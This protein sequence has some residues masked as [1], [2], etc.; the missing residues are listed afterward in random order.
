MSN[1]LAN[2]PH[3]E[4]V[5]TSAGCDRQRGEAHRI[6]SAPNGVDLTLHAVDERCSISIVDE[7]AV[8]D[9]PPAPDVSTLDLAG[10]VL[11][12]DDPHARRRDHQVIDVC[13]APW[14]ATTV[15]DD[16]CAAELAIEMRREATLA[17]CTGPP[18]GHRLRLV[19]QEL[20]H[21][22]MTHDLPEP[23]SCADGVSR[24][25]IALARDI[26]RSHLETLIERLTSLDK[27][28]PDADGD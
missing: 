6:E 13:G 7:E 1:G 19:T 26:A 9:H 24:S 21:R 15:E 4:S 23:A 25:R 11:R 20:G 3:S 17:L 8:V 2:S 12:V 14:H 5:N 28:T 18:G 16:G 10:V 22:S 27:A